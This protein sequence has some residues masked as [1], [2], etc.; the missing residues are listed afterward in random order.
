MR[1]RRGDVWEN[2]R[3]YH[4]Y[5]HLPKGPSRVHELK[6]WECRGIH[7][8]LNWAQ[9]QGV[10]IPGEGDGGRRGAGFELE[11]GRVRGVSSHGVGHRDAPDALRIWTTDCMRRR[12]AKGAKAPSK[13]RAAA[14]ATPW[15]GATRIPRDGA[16]R[17]P[18]GGKRQV[19]TLAAPM[20][21]SA[22]MGRVARGHGEGQVQT[23]ARSRGRVGSVGGPGESRRHQLAKAHLQDRGQQPLA[24][25]CG[26]LIC[27]GQ[28]G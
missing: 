25:L 7:P 6:T 17:T 2:V 1:S 20:P 4:V 3:G 24:L 18:R 11:R 13:T 27:V 8:E 26:Q 10:P 19:G 21:Q 16:R 28:P 12:L 23:G 5:C 14:R 15:A 22:V 9:T